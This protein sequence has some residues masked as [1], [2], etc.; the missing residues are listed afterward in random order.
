MGQILRPAI[1]FGD[2]G[3]GWN[4]AQQHASLGCL[5]LARP[6]VGGESKGGGGGGGSGGSGG[7]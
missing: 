4:T 6:Y 3:V 5:A 2:K 1:V 7:S